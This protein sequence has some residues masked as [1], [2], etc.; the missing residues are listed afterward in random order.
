MLIV[1]DALSSPDQHMT[2]N[3]LQS[4]L[5]FVCEEYRI[6]LL[7]NRDN[8]LPDYLGHTQ[9]VVLHITPDCENVHAP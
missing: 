1:A 9:C 2:L 6:L 4:K 5:G 7:S 3:T 8:V